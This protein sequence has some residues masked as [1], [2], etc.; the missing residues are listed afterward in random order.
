MAP[1]TLTPASNPGRVQHTL[2]RET[3]PNPEDNLMETDEDE[4]EDIVPAHPSTHEEEVA[5]LRRKLKHLS[6]QHDGLLNNAKENAKIAQSRIE[7]LE[8]KVTNLTN[9]AESLR[10]EAEKSQKLYREHI[11]HTAALVAT[12]KDPREILRPRQPD[13]FNGDA[14]KLQGFLTSLRSYQMYYPI[15]FTTEELRV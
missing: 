4:E 12:G 7:D 14:D 13:S 15:Q 9:L 10:T 11:E 6:Q 5:K 8:K 2:Q 3:P 1:I